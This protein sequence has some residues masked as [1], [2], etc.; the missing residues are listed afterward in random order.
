MEFA[1]IKGLLDGYK[2]FLLRDEEKRKKIRTVIF[3]VSG[4]SIADN[5][6]SIKNGELRI[7]ENSTIKNE[8]FLYKEKIF[9]RLQKNG[10]ND[11]T[12]MR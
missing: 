3:E 12:E 6:I 11:I 5:A 9:D 8:L 1:H 2:K 7:A 4:L 10:L